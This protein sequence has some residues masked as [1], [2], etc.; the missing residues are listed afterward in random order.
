MSQPAN[1]PGDENNTSILR[2][3]ERQQQR[4]KRGKLFRIA[5]VTTLLGLLVYFKDEFRLKAATAVPVLVSQFQLEPS[6][7]NSTSPSTDA[8]HAAFPADGSFHRNTL[9]ASA[10]NDSLP[11]VEVAN[12]YGAP[13]VL[14]LGSPDFS[15]N[16][17]TFVLHPGVSAAQHIPPGV[18]GLTL[19]MGQT[20]CNFDKGFTDGKR[21]K[22][23]K[24]LEVIAGQSN[25][26]K[27]DPI[28]ENHEGL[29]VDIIH[30]MSPVPIQDDH[31]VI[32][33]GVL[34]LHRQA[35]G[36]FYVDG[37]VNQVPANYQIDTGA[38]M[39]S[40]P[41]DIASR[42][43]IYECKPQTFETANGAVSG[44]VA[45]A[46]ELVFG[47]FRFQGFQVAVM[48]NMKGVLLGMNV[49]RHLRMENSGDLMRLS[50]GDSVPS[51]P[52]Q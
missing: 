22:I 28:G 42:A 38:S 30:A 33:N 52:L 12:G 14:L 10:Y 25:K 4:R 8:C 35:N 20:W 2:Y 43:G 49:L 27:L 21:I 51:A 24:P 16:D 40:I 31:K 15:A 3:L 23:T 37:A 34:E 50:T 39:T 7:S 26:I 41:Q 18:Y 44:C 36:G 46:R 29:H 17:R 11:L 45:T 48:P 13:V 5:L 9:D 19:L 47:N 1:Q 32:A 6:G